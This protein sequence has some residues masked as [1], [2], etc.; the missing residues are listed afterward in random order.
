MEQTFPAH[1]LGTYPIANNQVH[2]GDMPIEEGGN[3][4]ILAAA[5]S[6]IDRNV[7]YVKKVI[8]IS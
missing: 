2:G 4:V 1:D 8:G 7:D 6:K 3:M 5:I